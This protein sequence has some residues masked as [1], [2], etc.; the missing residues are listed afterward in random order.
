MSYI[1]LKPDE[2]QHPESCC[3]NFV[4]YY[5]FCINIYCGAACVAVKK[6]FG[7]KYNDLF[8]LAIVFVISFI[9]QTV[10]FKELSLVIK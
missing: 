7:C 3:G 2:K 8:C 5:S 9:F 4:N 6:H 10:I 1:H